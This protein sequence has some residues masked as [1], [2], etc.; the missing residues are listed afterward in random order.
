MA[1]QDQT[2]GTSDPILKA[3]LRAASRHCE[4]DLVRVGRCRTVI[5]FALVSICFPGIMLACFPVETN[6]G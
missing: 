1:I 4:K 2:Q 6:A 3:T 5:S